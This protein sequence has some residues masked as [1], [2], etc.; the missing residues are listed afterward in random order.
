MKMRRMKKMKTIDKR[1]FVC[2]KRFFSRFLL[3]HGSSLE[4]FINLIITFDPIA[5]GSRDLMMLFDYGWS[6]SMIRKFFS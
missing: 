5:Y 6:N 3:E 2:R 4:E 1:E